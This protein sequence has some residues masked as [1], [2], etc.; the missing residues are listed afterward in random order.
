VVYYCVELNAPIVE[1][2][3]GGA[4]LLLTLTGSAKGITVKRAFVIRA[5]NLWVL[6]VHHATP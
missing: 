6:A 4:E 3:A 2:V 1:D 5:F